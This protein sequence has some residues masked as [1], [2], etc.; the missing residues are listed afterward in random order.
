MESLVVGSGWKAS[1]EQDLIWPRHQEDRHGPR[2]T[3]SR[4]GINRAAIDAIMGMVLVAL[5][6]R[7]AVSR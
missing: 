6:L 7:L 2:P 4:E 3:L 1:L 5:G